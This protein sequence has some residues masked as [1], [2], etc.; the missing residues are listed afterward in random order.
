MKLN[1]KKIFK[2]QKNRPPYLFVDSSETIKFKKSIGKKNFFLKDYIFKL[3]WPND[4]NLPAAM[5]LECMTQT[6]S[7]ALLC[8]SEIKDKYCYVSK[9]ENFI[10]KKKII[11]PIQIRIFTK[12]LKFSRGVAICEG[13]IKDAKENIYSN[14]I[15][16]LIVPSVIRKLSRKLKCQ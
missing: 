13:V 9:V 5:H 1:K 4:P 11:P 10:L 7:L 14:S 16:T 12:I 2:I 6:A 15:F 8:D 3:H